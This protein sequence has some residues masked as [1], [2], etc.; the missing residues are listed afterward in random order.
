MKKILLA[1]ISV[2]FLFLGNVYALD[3]K[4]TLPGFG[5]TTEMSQISVVQNS[6]ITQSVSHP[7]SGVPAVGDSFVENGIGLVDGFSLTTNPGNTAGL[8]SVGGY[9]MTFTFD[10]LAGE[11]SGGN[12]TEVDFNFYAQGSVS[13]FIDASFD[14]APLVTNQ[15]NTPLPMGSYTGYNNGTQIAL[16]NVDGGYGDLDL[17]TGTGST[18]LYLSFVDNPAYHN[19]WFDEFGNDM[20]KDEAAFVIGFVDTTQKNLIATPDIFTAGTS[21]YTL[22]SSG[23]GGV[24]FA[25]PEPA[26]MTLFGFGLLC[27]AGISRR[28]KD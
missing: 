5:T 7:T 9:E 21:S 12:G 15:V 24:E 2:F 17:L 27:L 26:T 3:F 1:T 13:T 22:L 4:L 23:N 20:V 10:D 14:A 6:E 19:I 18:F 8:N 25:I 16:F 11:I 28:K